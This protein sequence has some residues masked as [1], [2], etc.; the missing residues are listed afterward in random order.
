M[1]RDVYLICLS[2]PKENREAAQRAISAT[3]EE[4]YRLGSCAT[5]VVDVGSETSSIRDKLLEAAGDPESPPLF[6]VVPV[7]YYGG[8][9]SKGLWEWLTKRIP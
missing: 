5:L 3:W 1:T 4:R 6:L 2:G 9:N 8:Y 7:D